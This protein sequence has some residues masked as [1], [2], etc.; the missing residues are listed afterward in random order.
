MIGVAQFTE[1]NEAELM[2][3]AAYEKFCEEEA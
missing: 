1:I 2:D 3:A